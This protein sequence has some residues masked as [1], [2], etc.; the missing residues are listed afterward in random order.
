MAHRIKSRTTTGTITSATSMPAPIVVK[1]IRRTVRD[2]VFSARGKLKDSN[3]GKPV[4]QRVFINDDLIDVNRRLLGIAR[5]HL[6]DKHLSGCWSK[7][8]QIFVK[9]NDGKVLR[10]SS[11]QD[12]TDA[13][14]V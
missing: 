14:N 5:S 1:F 9:L 8:C 4:A 7:N 2:E 3:A 10:I 11:I 12:L 6:R 13:L